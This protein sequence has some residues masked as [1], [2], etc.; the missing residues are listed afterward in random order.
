MEMASSSYVEN[1]P[2]KAQIQIVKGSIALLQ[3]ETNEIQAK[4]MAADSTFRQAQLISHSL[5]TFAKRAEEAR[6]N[7][8]IA[9][10]RFTGD[11]SILS[12]ASGSAELVFPRMKSTLLLGLIVALVTG[13]SAGFLAEFFDHTVRRPE[14]VQRNIGLPVLCSFS[15]L[16]QN[17]KV[18]TSEI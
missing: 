3:K 7:D 16:D 11:V 14:D 2:I 8:S 4:R 9:R 12:R 13:L 6:I 17:E 15:L 10:N 5:E 18:D 1:E